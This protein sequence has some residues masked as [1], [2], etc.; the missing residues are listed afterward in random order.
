M[1]AR[2]HHRLSWTA[3]GIVAL[4][5]E[6]CGRLL[7]WLLRER[8]VQALERLI[9]ETLEEEVERAVELEQS[10]RRAPQ[11]NSDDQ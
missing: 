11:E 5:R 4:W 6:G 7:N 1:T 8:E 10:R 9:A 2:E 3:K